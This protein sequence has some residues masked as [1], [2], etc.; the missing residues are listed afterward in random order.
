[1]KQ[2][3]TLFLSFW[4]GPLLQRA[5]S[6]VSRVPDQPFNLEILITPELPSYSTGWFQYNEIPSDPWVDWTREYIPFL[7]EYSTDSP[8]H[9]AVTGCQSATCVAKVMV[10]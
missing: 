10:L 5:S 1:M 8:M 9:G 7:K 2:T 6:V 3:L 4:D